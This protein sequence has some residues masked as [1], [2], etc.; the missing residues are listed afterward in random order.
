LINS[1][2][3]SWNA[4]PVFSSTNTASSP[5]ISVI[6]PCR[7]EENNISSLLSALN[8]QSYPKP[9]TEIIVVD[10]GSTD[11]TADIVKQFANIN[12]IYMDQQNINSYK[13]KAIETGIIA[14]HGAWIVTTDA[15]CVP[16]KN[17]LQT[18]ADFVNLTVPCYNCSSQWILWYC[19]KQPYIMQWSQPGLQ[20]ICI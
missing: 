10:D 12:L 8:Q 1:Y 17:W 9:L 14:A 6:I 5:T 13:K 18:I 11:N 4:A 3:L 20:E 7:N 2:W 16:C 19:R 15:D